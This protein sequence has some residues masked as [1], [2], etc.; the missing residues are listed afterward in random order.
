MD[1]ISLIGCI[2]EGLTLIFSISSNNLAISVGFTE[3]YNSLFSVASFLTLYS[4]F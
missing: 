2:N 3:P 4:F 1:F